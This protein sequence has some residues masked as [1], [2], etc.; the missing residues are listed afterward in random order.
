MKKNKK[1]IIFLFIL[2]VGLFFLTGLIALLMFPALNN[3]PMNANS[4]TNVVTNVTT[5]ASPTPEMMKKFPFPPLAASS[6]LEINRS[7]LTNV[8]KPTT[9]GDVDERVRSALSR[10]GYEQTGYYEVEGGGFVL[11]TQLEQFRKDGSVSP[12]RWSTSVEAPDFFS[13]DYFITLIAGKTGRFR[14]IAF[15][16]TDRPFS[17]D[18]NALTFEEGSGLMGGGN[19][20]LPD[21]F[22]AQLFTDR[23]R[24]T[25][26]I[27]E[28]T[29]TGATSKASFIK[30]SSL[31]ATT[32]LQPILTVLR[33]NKP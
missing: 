28:F 25:A 18:G 1:R 27:Y 19:P 9:L 4:N 10:G 31:P 23:H 13:Y 8:N 26:L 29:K 21:E 30:N 11:V 33:E 22:A 3:I 16:V 7:W 15:I 20:S 6:L 5:M 32:H 14:V 2:T 12:S 24:C 17:R